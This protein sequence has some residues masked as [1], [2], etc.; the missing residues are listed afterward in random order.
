M[1]ITQFLHCEPSIA[2]Q[3]GGAAPL[4]PSCWVWGQAEEGAPGLED[5]PE[6]AQP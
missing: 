6:G 1:L 4:L 3:G 5:C 2:E